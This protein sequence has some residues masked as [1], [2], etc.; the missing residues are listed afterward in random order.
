[1]EAVFECEE[2]RADVAPVGAQAS[3]VG[4][5]EFESGFPGFGAAVGEEDAVETADLGETKGEFG[6]V[7]VEEEVGGVEEELAL[8]LDRLFDG[9][10]GVAER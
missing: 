2:F 8:A 9:R 1:M 5:R 7:L 6:G 3:G 10:V 4:A